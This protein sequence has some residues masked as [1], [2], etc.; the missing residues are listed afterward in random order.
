MRIPVRT[1]KI[2]IGPQ[3]GAMQR[4][5]PHFAYHRVKNIPTWSGALQPFATSPVY[6]IAVS[7]RYPKS[8]RVHVLLPLLRSDA[9]HRYLDGS[10]CLYYPRDQS[11]APSM[12]I[13]ETIVPWAALWLAFYELWLQTGQWYG[14]EAPHHGPKR[15]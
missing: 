1:P 14:P 13:A 15:G 11:W 3:I 10:L 12:L 2:T 4:C 8:P 5:F 7:Y 9:P 6:K